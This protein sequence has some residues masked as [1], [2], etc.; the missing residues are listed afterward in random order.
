MCR[1]LFYLLLSF[2]SI[3]GSSGSLVW[4][5]ITQAVKRGA[6]CNDFSPAGYFIWKNNPISTN[7]TQEEKDALSKWVIFFESRGDC[8]TSRSCNKRFIQQTIRKQYTKTVNSSKFVN[9]TQAWHD[10]SNEPLTV[11]SRLMIKWYK[12]MCVLHATRLLH[13]HRKLSEHNHCCFVIILLLIFGK[14]I[15]VYTA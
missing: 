14:A 8:I 5:N 2:L 9:V 11:T 15:A 4:H 7:L 13:L 12:Y 6:L 10:Y 1:Y 3:S